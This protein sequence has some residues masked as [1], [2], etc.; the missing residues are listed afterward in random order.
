MGL[1]FALQGTGDVGD[2][3][4]LSDERQVRGFE[5]WRERPYHSV[6]GTFRLSRAVY[7]TRED[8][9]IDCVPLDSRLQL[10]ESEF[11]YLLQDWDQELVVENPYHKVNDVVCKILGLSQSVDSLE[12]MN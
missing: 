1:F 9:K 12:R 7:G 5:D 3:L 11:S 2:S 10:P 4:T 6:F 8:Q